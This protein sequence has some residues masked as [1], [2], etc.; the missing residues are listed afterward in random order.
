MCV[1]MH[2][3]IPVCACIYIYLYLFQSQYY[4]MDHEKVGKDLKS[5]GKN[6]YMWQK[7]NGK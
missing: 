1:S 3:H 5:E 2:M 6:K 7:N 4:N